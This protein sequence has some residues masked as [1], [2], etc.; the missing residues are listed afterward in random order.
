E[1][2]V[3][4]DGTILGLK[5]KTVADLGSYLQLLTP[6]I[7]TLTGLVITGCYRIPAIKL[8]VLGVYTNKM[9]TDAYRGA[10]RPEATYLIERLLDLVAHETG[11]DRV[12]VRLK[13][14]PQPSEF[15]FQTASGLFY[16]S[17]DYQKA[18]TKARE[19]VDWKALMAE[20][21]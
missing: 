6:A 19:L 15:P 9:S 18:L 21:T 17:G 13:N 10:G 5:A 4:N 2:A 1:V 3:K 20:R 14:F 11:L 12:D 8:E 16:D 7:P